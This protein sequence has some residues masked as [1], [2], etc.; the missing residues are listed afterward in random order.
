VLAAHDAAVARLEWL[1]EAREAP[2][3]GVSVAELL[4][5]PDQT[6]A[7]LY[8]KWAPPSSGSGGGAWTWTA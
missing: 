3:P 6:F 2:E 8:P 4:E 5:I 7:R 1:A